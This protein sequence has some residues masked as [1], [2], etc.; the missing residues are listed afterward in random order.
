MLELVR[1]VRRRHTGLYWVGA[2]NFAAAVVFVVLAPF[3]DRVVTGL[4]IWFK[5][6]K[7]ALSVG[8]YLWTVAWL[9]P[10]LRMSERIAR[11]LGWAIAIALLFENALI[12]SQAIRGTSSH[13]NVSTAYDGLVFSAMGALIGLNTVLAAILLVLY[14]VRPGG[15]ARP[16]LWGIRLG[17]LLLLAGSAGGGLMIAHGGH[18]VGASDGGASLPFVGWSTEA[19]DLRPTHL[20]SLHGLQVLPFL[21]FWLSRLDGWSPARRLMALFAFATAYAALAYWLLAQALAGRPLIPG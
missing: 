21:G 11:G 7:F 3:D 14:F 9:L 10:A 4:D 18:T 8:I 5:P 20:V 2:L 6:L 13:F 16:Y 12:F 1:E 19:G 15:V 17:Y